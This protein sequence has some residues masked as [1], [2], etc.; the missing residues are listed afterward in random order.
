MADNPVNIAVIK[1]RVRW[2]MAWATASLYAEAM[3]QAVWQPV[4]LLMVLLAIS[5]AGLWPFLPLAIHGV[6]FLAM[7]GAV[8][9]LLWN[10][11]HVP[12]PETS[13]VIRRVEKQSG[14]KNRPLTT[15][16]ERPAIDLHDFKQRRM[17]Q[18][19][20]TAQ[21]LQIKNLKTGPLTTN[22][23][24]HDPYTFRVGAGLALVLGILIGGAQS[25]SNL[26]NTTIPVD[27]VQAVLPDPATVQ[28]WVD[29]PSYTGRPAVVIPLDQQT[30]TPAALDVPDGSTL[31]IQVSGS[32][33]TP[34]VT[35]LISE[36]ETTV[37]ETSGA[38]NYTLSQK[39]DGSLTS[40]KVVIETWIHDLGAFQISTVVDQPPVPTFVRAPLQGRNGATRLDYTI[41]DDYGVITL[42]AVFQHEDT[43]I[44]FRS[45]I[46]L[47]AEKIREFT[48][49]GFL[50]L[51]PHP[52]AG[53]TVNLQLVARDEIDQEGLSAPLTFDMPSRE[54]THPVARQ[55]IDIRR[56][57][58]LQRLSNREAAT[59]LMA[60]HAFPEAYDD[61]TAV[62]LGLRVAIRRLTAHDIFQEPIKQSVI[63]MLWAMAVTLEDGGAAL[64]LAELREAQ[65]AL[66]EAIARGAP[67]EEIERLTHDVRQA[68][69]RYLQALAENAQDG[70]QDGLSNNNGQSLRSQDL[71]RI[72]ERIEQLTQMGD[73][74][75]AQALLQQLREIMESINMQRGQNRMS[76]SNDGNG[77]ENIMSTMGDLLNQQMQL[78]NESH[79]MGQAIRNGNAP[80]AGEMQDF[81]SMQN[82]L[83]RD[84]DNAI[85]SMI[86]EGMTPS[87]AMS[88]ALQSMEQ[89]T[90]ALGQQDPLSAGEAQ[91]QAIESLRDGMRAAFEELRRMAGDTDN[92]PGDANMADPL[93]RPGSQSTT[94]NG[95]LTIPTQTDV[96]RARE[97]LDEIYRRAGDRRRLQQE[98]D[99]LERL[100]ERF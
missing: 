3:I 50:D 70:T 27:I 81:S 34:S 26:V 39:L 89:A 9:W 51:T 62:Y 73:T 86:A 25:V 66:A 31:N 42:E 94:E 55:I 17:W 95:G 22:L 63:D 16:Y 57:L 92:S 54:L 58:A 72:L 10:I 80:E 60:V 19:H 87:E 91:G 23:S 1:S 98:R 13:V 71:Q 15:L 36:G 44:E 68:M 21:L 47:P 88:R 64:L 32:F 74:M 93:G 29:P 52:L 78:L 2:A 6:G 40:Q 37:F 85:T 67:P 8:L 38:Q 45:P 90:R 99:Y 14:L 28:V 61:D 41:Q 97:I 33:L 100:L 75:G 53:Q 69:Q 46:T 79:R 20:R 7:V 12:F 48:G 4:S 76:G 49:T 11:C 5:L 83:R 56:D 43:G 24:R 59:E 65:D 18:E 82:A 35:G 96:Q 30:G 84:L 77:E